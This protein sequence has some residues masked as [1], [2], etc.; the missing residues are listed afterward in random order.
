MFKKITKKLKF[1][2]SKTIISNDVNAFKEFEKRED[3][4]E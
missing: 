3:S 1:S 4:T 2:S